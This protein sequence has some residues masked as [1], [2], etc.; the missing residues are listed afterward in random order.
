M[1][2]LFG[3]AKPKTPAPTLQDAIQGTDSRVDSIQKK[4]DSL[5][6]ELMKYKQQMARMRPGCYFMHINMSEINTIYSLCIHKTSYTRA[7]NSHTSNR[8]NAG[9]LNTHAPINANIQTRIN[10]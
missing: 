1:D 5:D 8:T 2:R 6:Q 7:I 3:K 10:A 9:H 4:I